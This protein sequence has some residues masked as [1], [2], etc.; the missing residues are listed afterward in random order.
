M[1]EEEQETVCQMYNL[2]NMYSVPTPPEDLVVFATLPPSINSL[3]SIIDEAAAERDSS[4]DKLCSSLHKDIKE[5]ERGVMKI[6]VKSQVRGEVVF[7]FL[8]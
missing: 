1:L 5:L 3:H 8:Y 7:I 6:K 4:M 2:I